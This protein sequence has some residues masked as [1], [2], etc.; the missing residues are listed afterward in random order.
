MR[1]YKFIGL[2]SKHGISNSIELIKDNKIWISSF[3]KLNDPF[4]FRFHH[5]TEKPDFL[6][7][8]QNSNKGVLSLSSVNNDLLL[9][10]HY[11]TSHRG[12]CFELETEIDNTLKTACEI[13]YE[14]K[15]PLWD[16]NNPDK[17]LLTK[18]VAWKYESEYR[19]LV[20]NKVDTKIS[21]NAKA[22]KA[23]YF[24]VNITYSDIQKIYPLCKSKNINCYQAETI[25]ENYSIQ[26]KQIHNIKEFSSVIK[27]AALQLIIDKSFQKTR[28]LN[29]VE[30]LLCRK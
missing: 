22:I 10:S 3:D 13:K 8:L 15:M 5:Q 17:A 7:V 21:L 23:I 30:K 27:K 24:G 4:E 28:Q 20:P 29:L 18:A 6:S 12:V 25:N 26:F 9:W 2:E 14:E 11:G 16:Q 19:V 1:L